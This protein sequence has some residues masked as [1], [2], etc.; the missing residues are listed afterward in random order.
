MTSSEEAA[1]AALPSF[2]VSADDV[3]GEAAFQL[4]GE[5]TREIFAIALPDGA[6]PANFGFD[7]TAWHMGT[8]MLGSIR[9]TALDFE[10]TGDIVAASGIDHVMVQLYL[11]GGFAG[12]ADEHRIVVRPGDICVFDLGRTLRTRASDFHNLTLLVPRPFFEAAMADVRSL[13]GFVLG[14]D[15]PLSGL[16]A[17]HLCQLTARMPAMTARE[18]EVAAR[19]TVALI[20]AVLG[21]CANGLARPATEIASPF[22]NIALHID[23]RLRDADLEPDAIAAAFGM[24]RATLYRIFEP[25]GGV[26]DYIRRRR[27]TAAALELASPDHRRRK[28]GEIAFRWGFV[29]EAS[30]SRTF[31]AHFGISPKAARSQADR[32]WS[33]RLS[34]SATGTPEREFAIWMKTLRH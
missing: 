1:G 28:V 13:H 4:F 16:L 31:K 3:G 15:K 26:A 22:R 21:D 8:L 27:L 20:T 9:S 10:R 14:G 12:A 33:A 30:F 19:G 17:A 32:I 5:A 25:V 6:A 2:N 11:E 24:S 23:A 7:M 18:A 29:R 34:G